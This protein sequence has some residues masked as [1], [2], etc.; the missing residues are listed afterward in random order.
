MIKQDILNCE[1]SMMDRFLEWLS[2]VKPR[3]PKTPKLSSIDLE[4]GK[5]NETT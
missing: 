5:N 3:I 2:K 1:L 4:R